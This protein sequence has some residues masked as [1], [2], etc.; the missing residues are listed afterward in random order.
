MAAEQLDDVVD[1]F[2]DDI[3]EQVRGTGGAMDGT[4]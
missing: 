2:V 3:L 1:I 4:V